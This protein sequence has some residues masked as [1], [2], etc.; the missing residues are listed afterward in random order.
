[1]VDIFDRL[2][3]AKGPLEQY[4][5]KLEGYL[6]F[7]EL[8]GE[9]GP[10]MRFRG[11]EVITWSLNNYL[12]LANHPD[13]RKADAEATAKWG[14]AAPMGARMMSGQTKYHKELENRLAKFEKK[15]AAYLLN[16]GY[17]GMVS[18]LDSLCS[19]NDV[20]VYDSESHAC[21][22]DGIFLHKAKGGKSY[23]FPHNDME[24]CEKMLRFATKQ[25]E[26]N[27]GGI[28]VVTEGVFGMSGGLGNLPGIVKLKEKFNF[29]LLIDDAHGFGTMGATGAGTSEHFGVMDDVDIY[30]STFAKSMAGIGAFVATKKVI[31]DSLKSNMRSQI[32]AKSLPL[33]MVEGA[34]KRLDMLQNE[35]EHKENLW[36]VVHKLQDELR[37]N[38][39]DIGNTESPVTPVYLSGS[40]I[41][42]TNI[43]FDLRE[44]YNVFCSMVVYP[45]V[46]KNVLML[47]LIPT[48]AHTQKEVD[49][50]IEVFKKVKVNLEAGKYKGT[51][52]KTMRI[53]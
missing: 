19:R 23:V 12:G 42:G 5:S 29:R 47:R 25:A 38:G 45:V 52:M 43:V 15:E 9:I 40:V 26:E 27:N 4:Q 21:I 28:L 36:K 35:P 51:E 49:E 16:Y 1:M 31:I 50:T 48:S 18:I 39:F 17:Q 41:E 37:K 33:P 22:M 10:R 3:N 24:R 6:M 8:E 34:M 46:P 32:Y 20:I 2:T 53:D 13:V 44:T 11:K 7:P 14:L 30:F